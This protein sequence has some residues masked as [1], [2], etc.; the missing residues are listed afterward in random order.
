MRS[1]RPSRTPSSATLLITPSRSRRFKASN[2]L[3]TSSTR[4]GVVDSSDIAPP[5]IPRKEQRPLALLVLLGLRD[6]DGA[7]A[8]EWAVDE[9]DLHG[10][11]GLDVGLAEK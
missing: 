2:C 6:L 3:R 11:V 5:S 8:F 10:D 1:A 4:S 7:E 9:K